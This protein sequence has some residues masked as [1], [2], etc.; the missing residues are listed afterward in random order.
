MSDDLCDEAT[1]RGVV[2]HMNSDHPDACL[3]IVQALAECPDA[4][5]ATMLAMDAKGADFLTL[6]ANTQK[7]TLRVTFDKPITRNSQ[8]RGHLVALTK[9]ARAMLNN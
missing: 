7:L 8:I 2:E 5:Q 6:L 9:R 1:T 4:T 3:A